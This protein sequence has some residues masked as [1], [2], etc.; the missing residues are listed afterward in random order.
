MENYHHRLEEQLITQVR[1]IEKA[2]LDEDTIYTLVKEYGYV[3]NDLKGKTYYCYKGHRLIEE[4]MP[5]YNKGSMTISF[6]LSPSKKKK[7]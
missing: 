5:T 7:K 2:P 1:R 6:K 4:T 3:L